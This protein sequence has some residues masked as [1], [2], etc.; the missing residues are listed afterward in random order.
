MRQQWLA[1]R[2]RSGSRV[3]RDPIVVRGGRLR[4]AASAACLVVAVA[5]TG[6]SAPSDPGPIA[7]IDE[8]ASGYV[9]DAGVA[10]GDAVTD[11][12]PIVP[13]IAGTDEVTIHR[14]EPVL[15][16]DEILEPLGVLIAG[17]DRD[18]GAVQFLHHWP[19]GPDDGFGPLVPAEG[20][21]LEPRPGPRYPNYELLAGYRVTGE[22]RGTVE[23]Y[24]ITYESARQ[25]YTVT[26]PYTLAICTDGR[27]TC[28]PEYGSWDGVGD[29]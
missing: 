18:I 11:G 26:L 25:V 3:L 12:W 1:H 6:S 14:I 22:G 23:A 8:A 9:I 13:D 28:E 15:G 21:T 24:T 5:C 19:P 4:P 27:P 16:G 2:R 17:D 29:E 20:A 10:V 7:V